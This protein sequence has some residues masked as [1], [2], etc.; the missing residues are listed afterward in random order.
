MTVCVDSVWGEVDESVWI[1]E[2]MLSMCVDCMWRRYVEK[3]GEKV[4]EEK[5][6]EEKIG[7][8]E[9]GEKVGEEVGEEKIGEDVPSIALQSTHA[10]ET[11]SVLP[12]MCMN[13]EASIRKGS[14]ARV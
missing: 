10:K 12:S 1:R 13:N 2:G 11:A 3:V 9:V 4:G 6:G 14:R 7:E 5:V 8:E